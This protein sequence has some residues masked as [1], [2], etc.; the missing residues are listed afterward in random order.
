MM[1]TK[2]TVSADASNPF[3]TIRNLWPYMWPSDRPDLKLRVLYAS[4]FL[5]LAKIV[6]IL[7]PYFF[8]WATNALNGEFNGPDCPS[9]GT[10]T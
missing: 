6:L 9:R 7:V 2:K 4:V 1:D 5:V 3:G 10:G 8:K